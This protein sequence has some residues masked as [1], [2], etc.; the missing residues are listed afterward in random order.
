MI[1]GVTY[2][3]LGP[4]LYHRRPLFSKPVSW[5]GLFCRF[6]KQDSSSR[7]AFG[8]FWYQRSNTPLVFYLFQFTLSRIFC[9]AYSPLNS[10]NLSFLSEVM[11]WLFMILPLIIETTYPAYHLIWV[12]ICFFFSVALGVTALTLV[13]VM[14]IACIRFCCCR[15]RNKPLTQSY[16]YSQV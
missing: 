1:K 14:V 10:A 12:L 7:Q 11:L 9:L 4:I 16:R 3:H 6:L 13:L 8:S 5:L 2:A 15:N